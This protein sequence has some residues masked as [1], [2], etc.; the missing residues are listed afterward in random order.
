MKRYQSYLLA[1][2]LGYI[3]HRSYYGVVLCLQDRD[4]RSPDELCLK[5]VIDRIAKVESDRHVGS[6]E[7]VST[8]RKLYTK[9]NGVSR[10]NLVICT[11]YTNGIASGCD[12]AR[13]KYK[14]KGVS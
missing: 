4:N 5:R 14:G 7:G 1:I 2:D 11:T 3:P 9:L 10:L 8:K 13:T 6:R 12:L